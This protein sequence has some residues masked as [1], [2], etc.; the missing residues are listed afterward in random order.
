VSSG[1]EL[2]GVAQRGGRTDGDGC[3]LSALYVM[4]RGA[5]GEREDGGGKQ[6]ERKCMARKAHGLPSETGS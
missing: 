1:G 3:G 6:E 4:N 2:D 5:T